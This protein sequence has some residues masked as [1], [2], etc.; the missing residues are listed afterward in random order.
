MRLLSYSYTNTLFGYVNVPSDMKHKSSFQSIRIAAYPAASLLALTV[1]NS[2]PLLETL[3]SLSK[4]HTPSCFCRHCSE[5]TAAMCDRLAWS[6]FLAAPIVMNNSM[7]KQSQSC[8]C[9]KTSP[10]D[11]AFIS[12]DTRRA[13]LMSTCRK[14][15]LSWDEYHVAV[16]ACSSLLGMRT[17]SLYSENVTPRGGDREE[18]LEAVMTK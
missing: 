6:A 13:S 15:F 9:D 11:K 10:G 4:S 16:K 2:D 1:D 5:R 8:S 18:T 12:L 14:W 17:N 7:P 3:D